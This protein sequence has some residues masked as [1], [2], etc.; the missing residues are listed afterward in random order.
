[1]RGKP[2]L[3][4]GGGHAEAQHYLGFM[5]D[6]G[7]GVKENDKEAVKWYRM[8]AEQGNAKSQYSLG[9]AYEQGNGVTRDLNEALKYYRLAAEQ[10]EVAAQKAVKRLS[11]QVAG[12]RE[13]Q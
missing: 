1:M 10:G 9:I 11:S 4:F 6:F 5:Y 3:R 12:E 7:L 2:L 8:A 13:S